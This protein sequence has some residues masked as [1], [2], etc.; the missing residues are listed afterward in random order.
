MN[1]D[2]SGLDAYNPVLPLPDGTYPP[3]RVMVYGQFH[4]G[5]TTSILALFKQMLQHRQSAGLP[6]LQMLRIS[7]AVSGS[8]LIEPYVRAGLAM[9]IRVAEVCQPRNGKSI[10][11]VAVL[12][13][14]LK[15]NI[16]VPVP[17]SAKHS[18]GWALKP[19]D[20]T[21]VGMLLVEDVDNIATEM[22]NGW[23]RQGKTFSSKGDDMPVQHAITGLEGTIDTTAGLQSGYAMSHYT[24]ATKEV[25]SFI[26]DLSI[27]PVP[28]IFVTTHEKVQDQVHGTG[29]DK[30]KL[31]RIAGPA[32]AGQAGTSKV[33]PLSDLTLHYDIVDGEYRIYYATHRDTANPALHWSATLRLDPEVKQHLDTL[34]ASAQIG[35]KNYMRPQL[36]GQHPAF[37]QGFGLFNLFQLTG[38]LQ[39]QHLRDIMGLA[40]KPVTNPQQ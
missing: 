18:L 4:A 13:H 2:M 37:P 25:V 31:D 28:F 39:D 24:Q 29:S 40:T 6:M 1:I 10:D 12:Q 14:I 30:V 27:L 15:G 16:P 3:R 17:V 23:A 33:L 19:I 21:K 22:M 26:N 5:K 38:Y 8:A 35:G 36:P 20:W 11:M 9:D 34:L 32:I 7:G